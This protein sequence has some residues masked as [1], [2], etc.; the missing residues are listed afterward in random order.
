GAVEHDLVLTAHLVEID[1][2]QAGF[3]HAGNDVVHAN[4]FLA[5]LEGRTVRH[6]Q[7]FASRLG[8]AFHD[9][10]RPD[11]FADRHANTHAADVERAGHGADGEDA[12]FV[13]HAVIGQ[14]DLAGD[15]FHFARVEIDK[16][17][18]ELA[19]L[20][21]GRADEHGGATVCGVA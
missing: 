18:V 3:R 9:I 21:P 20:H 10:R 17:V 11:V 4:V 8:K 19:L 16:G 2:R 5:D 1:E 12:L 7:D 6:Q 14:I 15:A 13:E